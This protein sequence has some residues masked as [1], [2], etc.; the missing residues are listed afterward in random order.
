MFAGSDIGW[1]VG[2]QFTVYGP[3]LRGAKTVIFEGKPVQTPDAGTYWRVVEKAKVKHL[4]TAPTAIRAIRRDDR[5]GSFT[6][7][8]D[9][10]SL[11]AIS[12]AGERCDIPTYRW[13]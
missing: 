6:S 3:L 9:I 13:L 7:M 10:S 11:K 4:Y 2:H 12:L 5:E 1:V 8:Y